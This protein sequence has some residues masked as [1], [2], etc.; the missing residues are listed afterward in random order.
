MIDCSILAVQSQ[1]LFFLPGH[2]RHSHCD[3]FAV[4]KSYKKWIESSR[5]K[6]PLKYAMVSR[7]MKA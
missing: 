7:S 1:V 2:G 6:E 4:S 5:T 3:K